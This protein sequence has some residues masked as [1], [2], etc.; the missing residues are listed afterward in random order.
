MTGVDSQAL[1]PVQTS[2][3]ASAQWPAR[4]GSVP[5]LADRF[6]TRPETGPD[7]KLALGRT[8]AVMLAPRGRRVG[9]GSSQDWLRCSGKTQLAAFFAE[10]QWRAGALD[11]L[12]W[13]DAS[14]MSSILA[15]YVDAAAVVTGTRSAG[16]AETVAAGF[17]G[18]LAQTDRRWLVVLDDLAD[19]DSLA[20]RWPAG[21]TGQVIVTT[22]STQ[23]VTSASGAMVLE[24]GPFSRREAMSYLVGRLSA[25][26]DQRRGAID[27]IEDLDCHPIAI[28]QATATI[29]TSWL[30]CVDY[31]E[32]YYRRAGVLTPPGAAPPFAPAVTWTLA[33]DAS[34]QPLPGGSA[35]SCLAM[36]SLLDG[37]GIPVTVFTTAAAT[38]YIRGTRVPAQ[39]PAAQRESAEWGSGAERA[40][41]GN[42]PAG[43]ASMALTVLDQAGLI[44]IDRGNDPPLVRVNTILQR[45]VRAATPRE[46]QEAASLAAATALLEAWPDDDRGNRIGQ[47]LR[48]S[49]ASLQRSAGATL[50]AHGCHPVLLR[51]GKSL[52][53]ARLSGPAVDYWTGLMSIA[54]QVI[55]PGHP[56]A[57]VL[58]ERLASAYVAA[59]RAAEAVSWHQRMMADWA[60]AFGP[61]HP[62]TL[63]ARVSLGRVL[64]SAGIY[65]EAIRVMG[66]ALA[67]C[68]RA[69]GPGHPECISIRTEVAAGYRA[70]GDLTEAIRL[71]KAALD[72]R[73]RR[74]GSEHPDTMASRQVL[75][76]TY[77]AAGRTKD[78]FSQYKRVVA[79]RQ[80]SQGREHPDTLRATGALASA[81]QQAGK[82]A[83]A[84]QLSEQ[85]R[86]GTEKALGPDH[87]DTLAA[88]AVLGSAYYTAG[89][90]SDA[91]TVFRDVIARGE[92]VLSPADPLTQSAR[93]GL[94]TITGE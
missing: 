71:Y 59:G 50:W 51:A 84:I 2:L 64:V 74:F 6:S 11:L 69:Y 44:T 17:L 48:A 87:R 73:D 81:Y 67:D 72:E 49:A 68:E 22:S 23:A 78:A 60:R 37:H 8:G 83:Q 62:R 53:D 77:L 36:A 56:D 52:D 34:D 29:G 38:T 54:D 30:T 41:A 43:T 12:V 91:S 1:P 3:Q 58:V 35:Q 25:D 10:S 18:W 40:P 39:R 94:A 9:A 14:S 92:R 21:P 4:S 26:P 15:D 13:V 90:L 76:E 79:D 31:R 45:A 70:A 28:A 93:D 46:M 5:A 20:G 57:L 75:A 66:A 55:G 33:V 63:A 85:V 88:A 80:R 65:E 82:M 16:D 86:L 61:D 89:R 42:Q 19:P 32:H 24:I 27:L 47:A 7:L